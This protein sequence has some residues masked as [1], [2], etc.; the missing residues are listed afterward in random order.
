MIDYFDKRLK[1]VLES[2]RDFE[3]EESAVLD[4]QR[5]L[6]AIQLPNNNM[7]LRLWL[8]LL[9]LIRLFGEEVFFT[10]NTKTCRKKCWS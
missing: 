2:P 3:P 5:R 8:L 4:I 7:L 1:D 6:R 9:L 10:G